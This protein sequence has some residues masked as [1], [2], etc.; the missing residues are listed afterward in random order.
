MSTRLHL[1]SATPLSF[2]VSSFPN[3]SWPFAFN[4]TLFFTYI[5]IIFLSN[6]NFGLCTSLFGKEMVDF[7]PLQIVLNIYALFSAVV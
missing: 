4:L 7:T 2:D 6:A 5:C 3:I 1:R